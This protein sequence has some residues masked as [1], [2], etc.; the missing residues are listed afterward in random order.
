M[1]KS[2][3]VLYG[4]IEKESNMENHE[5]MV[6]VIML[7]YNHEKYIDTAIKSILR[8]KTNFRYEILVSDD[9]SSD[10]TGIKLKNYKNNNPEI[11]KLFLREKRIGCIENLIDLY[12]NAK[13]KYIAHIDGDDYWLDCRKLQN[14]YDFLEANSNYSAVFG[15]SLLIDEDGM[16][17]HGSI[18]WIN[19]KPVYVGSDFDGVILPGQ[20]ST[21]FQRNIYKD[22]PSLLECFKS[23]EYIG[24]RISV[25][26][27]L[28][29]GKIAC[30]QKY[31]GAYRFVRK[32]QSTNATSIAYRDKYS[33]LII[34]INL[35]NALE[36]I[37]LRYKIKYRRIKSKQLIF[38]RAVLYYFKAN[39][40]DRKRIAAAMSHFK[41][42]IFYLLG[43]GICFFRLLI[44]K[45][46]RS[47][48]NCYS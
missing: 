13:G 38:A 33:G 26:L 28:K 45:A 41:G 18:S 30:A 48:F 47:A 22:D 11:I 4:R 1:R 25:L 35:C 42:K 5:I 34:D 43:I 19:S 17:I 39:A 44:D 12:R 32:P 46:R 10:L 21:L 2:G 16:R 29:Y 31:Y 6:S 20:T 23:S 27:L 37:A 24:D 14:Q 3:K 40:S 36:N 7:C 15:K 8:Q 9:H